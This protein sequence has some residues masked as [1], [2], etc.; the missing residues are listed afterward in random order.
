MNSRFPRL[1]IVPRAL[2]IVD[3]LG[4]TP[5]V[6][7]ALREAAREAVATL[8]G[9]DGPGE[10][11]IITGD[12]PAAEQY[13]DSTPGSFRPYGADVR[14]AAGTALPELLGRWLIEDSAKR[15]FGDTVAA[16]CY[17]HADDALRDGQ[18]R[19]LVLVD[20][21]FGLADNSPVGEIAGAAETDALCRTIAGHSCVSVD[22]VGTK[23]PAPGEYAAALWRELYEVAARWEKSD[24]VDVVKHVYYSHAPYGI[25]YHVASWQCVGK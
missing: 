5:A 21:A 24:N 13:H 18:S 20:G 2:L 16:T 6:A 4:G 12:I 10:V 11:A 15:L 23:F 14:V 7:V 19:L 9:A 22:L 17:A 8:W 25:G 1:V 3:E